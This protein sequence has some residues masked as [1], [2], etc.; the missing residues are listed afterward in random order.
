MEVAMWKACG[1][2]SDGAVK[3]W[4][5]IDSRAITSPAGKEWFGVPDE[6][7]NGW[8]MLGKRIT[9]RRSFP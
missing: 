7:N 9:Y 1:E 2:E 4:P 3:E 8:E 6:Q 5:R